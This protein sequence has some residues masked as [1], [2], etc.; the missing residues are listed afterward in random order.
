[1]ANP[2]KTQSN[3]PSVPEMTRPTP[4]NPTNTIAI[5]TIVGSTRTRQGFDD[6]LRSGFHLAL[7][8]RATVRDIMM[9]FVLRLPEDARIPR[10]ARIFRTT[11]GSLFLPAAVAQS[12]SPEKS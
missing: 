11:S 1:M 9:P 8:S 6:A 3:P 2:Q 12:V 5:Q 7:I 10:W 4:Q